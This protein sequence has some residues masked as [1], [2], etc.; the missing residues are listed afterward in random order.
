MYTSGRVPW[1]NKQGKSNRLWS[2]VRSYAILLLSWRRLVM[3]LAHV[4]YR[5]STDAEYA[6]QFQTDPET[7]LDKLGLRLSKE[8]LASLL[9]VLKGGGG[10]D[11]LSMIRSSD[12]T[13]SAI[14]WK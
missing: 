7:T 11:L 3:E 12:R 10:Q 1:L 13:N 14:G 8:E 6:A 4:V 9:A 2:L 5:V